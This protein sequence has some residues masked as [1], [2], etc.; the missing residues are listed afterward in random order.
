MRVTRI[1]I[2]SV[3]ACAG[4][5][6][7]HT[8]LR[9]ETMNESGHTDSTRSSPG[10][11]T[12]ERIETPKERSRTD[13]FRI[14]VL[15]GLGFPRP[16]AIE[17][18]VKVEKTLGLGLEYSALPSLSVSGVE[19]TFHALAA[20]ARFF[21]FQGPFFIGLRA[22]RQHLGGTGTLS[23]NGVTAQGSVTV[24]TTFVNPRIGFLWTFEPGFSV[25]IDAGV[26]IP[27]ASNV[28]T[29]LPE[30]AVVS[31]EAM[32]IART[33]GTSVIPTVDLIRLGFLL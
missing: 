6:S 4:A 32:R 8:T 24:D 15:G 31:D 28:S 29:S 3:G 14:G 16:L 25:G 20:D 9:A 5:S 11:D 18:M 23:A 21:P 30:G 10:R 17:G 2:L 19:T 13:H 33:F 27:V 1:F 7:V 12:E 22:G 26:Q